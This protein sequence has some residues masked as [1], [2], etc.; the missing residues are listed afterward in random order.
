[1][2]LVF[3]SLS[4]SKAAWLEKLSKLLLTCLKFHIRLVTFFGMLKKEIYTEYLCLLSQKTFLPGLPNLTTQ[5]GTLLPKQSENTTWT[6]FPALVFCIMWKPGTWPLLQFKQLVPT[7]CRIWVWGI[8]EQIANNYI[9]TETSEMRFLDQ[10]FYY[11]YSVFWKNLA[12]DLML[13]SSYFTGI[14]FLHRYFSGMPL[15]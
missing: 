10:L 2:I 14:G 15:T 12:V 7:W 6:R 11:F 9:F 5:I 3:V 8:M 4:V 1:M 13:F